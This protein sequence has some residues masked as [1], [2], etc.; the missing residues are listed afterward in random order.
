MRTALFT[1]AVLLVLV[2]GATAIYTVDR[3]E[4]VYVT[5]FG[6]HVATHDGASDGGLH[7]KLPWPVQSVQ[8]LDRR[9]QYFDLPETELLTHD[10]T[11]QTIDK[12][13]TV[14]AYVCWRI[15]DQQ[16]VDWFIR[17]V[18]QPE[19]AKTILGE[20]I[21]SQLGAAIGRM[22]MDD[23]F[24]TDAGRV[25]RNLQDLRDRL[26]NGPAV[27]ESLQRRAHED[28]G[29]DIVDIRLRR[30]NHPEA[31]R[32]A[33][34]ARIRSEREK[35]AA[36]YRSE[37]D[38]L[39]ADIASAAERKARDIRSEARATERK[40][41]GQAEAEADH[42]RNQAHSK[43]PEFYAFLKKLEEYQRILGDNKTMLL[44]SSHRDLF[45]LLFQPPRPGTPPAAVTSKNGGA[46]TGQ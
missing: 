34:F 45:D 9:L 16:S 14:V 5:Q 6:Q 28:Y 20:R 31:V 42:I 4:Y 19:R 18:G 2:L 44:L 24:S 33:I 36:E 10:A 3:A 7:V 21:R 17:R 30:T 41:K 35:K 27:A 1:L 13:L 22:K 23:L 40:L 38:K 32:Q 46:R 12:T 11:G 43:D 8:R 15:A 39:A 29:I 26:L 25:E 37:G